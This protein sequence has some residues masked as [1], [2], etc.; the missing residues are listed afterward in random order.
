M[1]HTDVVPQN[2][3]SK[4]LL[5]KCC[6]TDIQQNWQGIA[7]VLVLVIIRGVA[8]QNASFMASSAKEHTPE[9]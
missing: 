9:L 3:K 4:Q 8:V 5:G 1:T 7:T 2:D 6:Q